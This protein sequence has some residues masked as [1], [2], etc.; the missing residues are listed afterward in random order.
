M[1]QDLL[2]AVLEE[3]D[4]GTAD[5]GPPALALATVI[6]TWS[7]A[8]RPAGSAMAVLADGRVIGSVSGGCVEGAV[9]LAAAEVLEGAPARVERYGVSDDEAF[10]VGLTCGGEVSIL[11]Q[12]VDA[13]GAAHLRAEAAA[14]AEG[15]ACVIATVV[16]DPDRHLIVHADGREEDVGGLDDAH[17][18]EAV[19]RAAR[20]LLGAP[21]PQATVVLIDGPDA[22][23][24]PTEVFLDPIVPPPDLYVFGA[25][26]FAGSVAEIGAFLGHR[27][28]VCDARAVFATPDRFPAAH[29]VVVDWPHRFLDTA[30]IDDR[31]A[32][33]VLTHDAKYDVPAL[34]VALRSPAGYVG[35]MGSRRTCEDRAERLRAEGL[36]EAELARLHAPIGLDLGASSPAETAVA[37]AAELLASRRAGSGRALRDLAGPIHHQAPTP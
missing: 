8:P 37:I 25:T 17:L 9:Y 16:A 34:L 6:T 31:T 15:R 19:A 13:E 30:P 7:S 2:D 26:D 27:V 10:G 36:T 1:D 12:R 21:R 24:A 5:A 14:R 3:L 20:D 23:T 22:S 11:V 35:A 33:C 29:R 18:D 4:G 28:T 32:I